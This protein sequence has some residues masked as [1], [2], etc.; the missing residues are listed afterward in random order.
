MKDNSTYAAKIIGH[1]DSIGSNKFNQILSEKRA[2]ATKAFMVKKGI[3][4][5]RITTEGK[6][7]TSPIATNKTKEGQA[8]NRR[9]E[10]EI[11]K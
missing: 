8:Q 7:E 9:I 6:G 4:S 2:E 11:T 10:V 5:S 1:T 3:N